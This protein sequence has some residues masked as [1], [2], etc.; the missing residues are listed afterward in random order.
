MLF[1]RIEALENKI[2]AQESILS[3]ISHDVR[4]P[5]TSTL[6]LLN[7]LLKTK[8]E[9]L[10][11]RQTSILKTLERSTTRQLVL[12]DD[13]SLI[14]KILRGRL[15]MEPEMIRLAGL[16]DSCVE[17]FRKEAMEKEITLS[18]QTAVD[19]CAYI[20]KKLV[21]EGLRQIV[22]NAIWFTKP[23]GSVEI[24][25]DDENGAPSI[26][27]TDTGVGMEPEFVDNLFDLGKRAFSFGTRDEK[28]AGLGLYIARELIALNNGTTSIAS[29]RAKGTTAKIIFPV[30]GPK[31]L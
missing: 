20:D 31:Q 2:V 15:K 29:T 8:A 17:E 9:N 22:R 7:L 24:R 10:N 4:S 26:T 5:L 25:T 30:A 16:V 27:V 1:A 3:I 13:L 19:V 12:V 21:Q 6:G 14:S 28:G 23:G 18:P 11:D